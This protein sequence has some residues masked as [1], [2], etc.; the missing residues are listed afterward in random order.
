MKY[1]NQNWILF[2]VKFPAS[3]LVKTRLAEQLGEETATCLYKG[4]VTDILE[5]LLNLKVN[6]DIFFAPS[7]AQQK[8]CL[9]LGNKYS[10]IPQTGD[11]LGE[12]MK[13]AFEHAF[14]NNC[15][16]VIIIGSDSPDLPA[17]FFNRSFKALESHDAIVGPSG[18][19]GYYLIGFSK[20]AFLSEAFESV[21]WSTPQVCEQTLNILKKHERDVYLLPQWYDVDTLDD[22]KTIVSRN[23]NTAFNKSKTFRYLTSSK[24]WS[25][26]NV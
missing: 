10:Y 6:F 14:T 18:D 19:G 2:F 24:F 1:G 22:L 20:D 12:K 16:R 13:N 23:V 25:E 7:D 17:E 3:G 11:N 9:W 8:F 4:F 21:A 26:V 5:N 15:T